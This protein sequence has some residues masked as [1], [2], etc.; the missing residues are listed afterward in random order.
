MLDFNAVQQRGMTRNVLV[1]S[2][3][4]APPHIYVIDPVVQQLAG[5]DYCVGNGGLITPNEAAMLA[6]TLHQM[7]HGLD[8][9]EAERDAARVELE[10]AQETAGVLYNQLMRWKRIHRWVMIAGG[11]TALVVGNV[12]FWVAR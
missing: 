7:G 12:L 9:L 5:P 1:A 3:Q 10:E 8:S 11:V 4:E 6:N 2:G